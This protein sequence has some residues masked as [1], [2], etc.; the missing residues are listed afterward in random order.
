ML[1]LQGEA[2]EAML[3]GEGNGAAATVPPWGAEN[4]WQLG[5]LQGITLARPWGQVTGLGR[6]PGDAG[7]GEVG[8]KAGG[9]AGSPDLEREQGGRIASFPESAP[10]GTG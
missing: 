3:D 1:S 8:L 9:D 7:R 5:T 10:E 2:G 4:C 6:C